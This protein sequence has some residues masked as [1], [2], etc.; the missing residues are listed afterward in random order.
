[1]TDE[2]LLREISALPPEA[3]R[4]VEEFIVYLRQR[5]EHQRRDLQR[6]N[7]SLH[8]EGFIG[9]WRDRDEMK[10]SS[11]WVRGIRESEWVK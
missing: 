3:Q 7:S 8:E 10:D 6:E 9:M 4:E 1:M 11:A 2:E 5:Y